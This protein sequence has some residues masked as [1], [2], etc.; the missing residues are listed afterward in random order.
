MVAKCFPTTMNFSLAQI[1][2]LLVLLLAFLASGALLLY[3]GGNVTGAYQL[4]PNQNPQCD[5]ERCDVSDGFNVATARD[6]QTVCDTSVDCEAFLYQRSFYLKK[7]RV[8]HAAI[9]K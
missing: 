7:D 8:E 3:K 4:Y 6:C 5:L 2:I 1:I 9:N